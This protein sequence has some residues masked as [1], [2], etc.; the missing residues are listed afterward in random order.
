MNITSR[1]LIVVDIDISIKSSNYLSNESTNSKNSMHK[2]S[3]F[4]RQKIGWV[5][6]VR[7]TN[8]DNHTLWVVFVRKINIFNQR[9]GSLMLKKL[10]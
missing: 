10:T 9:L 2:T 8:M 1:H 7:K 5:V 6:F 4:I 3:N